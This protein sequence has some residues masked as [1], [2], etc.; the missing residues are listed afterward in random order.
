MFLKNI[1]LYGFKSFLQDTR[2][3]LNP[4]ISVI[5]GPNG[6]G[7]SNVIDA[8][9]WAL[10]E[11]RV[12]ELRAERWEDLLHTDSNNHRAKMAE[13]SLLFDNH[14]KEM[15]DWPESL[16]ITRRYYLSGD[17]EYLLNGRV[18]RLKDIVDL[19]LDSGIG[20]FN[21]AII[22]QG[23]VEA[24]LLM[25]PKERLEQLEEAAGV[26]RYKVKRRETLQHLTDVQ[27]NLD[28]IGDLIADVR[29]Q[30]EEIAED[31]HVEKTYLDI[32]HRYHD[33][34]TRYQ[35]TQYLQAMQD[36]AMWQET[37]ARMN[38]RRADLEVELQ[39]LRSERDQKV[40]LQGQ[41]KERL[42]SAKNTVETKRQSMAVID[43]Y[44]ARLEAEQEGLEREIEGLEEQSSKITC[45]LQDVSEKLANLTDTED[46]ADLDTVQ[47]AS[48]SEPELK[49]M[50]TALDVK[51]RILD[52]Q[53]QDRQ[54]QEAIIK[55][56][57]EETRQLERRRD[58]LE[59]ALN[60]AGHDDLLATVTNW[61][62]EES[63]LRTLYTSTEA[64]Y[65]D[66][67]QTHRAVKQELALV[68]KDIN[69]AQQD[70]WRIEAQIKALRSVESEEE[71]MP[72]S[73]RAVLEMGK[74]GQIAGILG[75]VGSLITIPPRLHRAIDVALR[76]QRYFVI[77]D[78]EIHARH[79]VDW[80]KRQRAG[81]VTLLPLDQIRPALV[82]DRDR[83]LANQPG[84]IGWALDQITFDPELFPA[85]S[86]VLGR[87]LVIESLEAGNALGRLHQFRYR[88][89]SVD[90]Q[91]ILSGGAI[92]GGSES[93]VREKSGKFGALSDRITQL[94]EVLRQ[95]QSR[96]EQLKGE[97]TGLEAKEGQLRQSLGH[98]QERLSQL[99]RILQDGEI[100]TQAV[101]D[102]M[103]ALE[104]AGTR[105]K[106]ATQTLDTTLAT[107]QETEQELQQLKEAYQS[108][109]EQYLHSRQVHSHRLEL[110]AYY[111]E[112]SR[113]LTV[114]KETIQQR[115][116]DLRHSM[117]KVLSQLAVRRQERARMNQQI[118]QKG[119]EV[120]DVQQ[121]LHQIEDALKT[122]EAKTQS[123]MAEDRKTAG[124]INYLEQQLVRTGAKWE[125]YEPAQTEPLENDQLPEAKKMLDEWQNTME[126]LGEVHPGVYALFTQLEKRLEYLEA[127]R[128][129]V[130]LSADELRG[131]LRQIDQEVDLRITKTAQQVETAFNQACSAL[132]G[133]EGGFRWIEGEE[134]GVELRITP[135]GK[136]PGTLSLLSGG[137]KALGGI[138]W[139]FA[140]LSVK[141]S[142]FV[143][144]DEA[145]AALDEANAH[146]VAEYIREHRGKTQY[147]IVTHHK[148]TMAIAD[149]LWGVAGDGKGRSRLVS[150]QI[151]QMPEVREG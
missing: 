132:L 14:D 147:V 36:Q 23:R 98:Y 29:N 69:E 7:K 31:A 93:R 96:Q 47:K 124:R 67:K 19:F 114:Q 10:G 27:R 53:I 89:V 5:V 72:F 113:Q 38:R 133:G 135:P 35:L 24:A 123:I 68:N 95:R 92:S 105:L 84:A 11:Q 52:E 44:I 151:E 48:G 34:Q 1:V 115:L 139:L 109:H 9:R 80:L 66:V 141:S 142:P 39:T 126:S 40:L 140:L 2:V 149:A 131:T 75:T 71:T 106:Q 119:K 127:E 78:T 37:L 6:G 150:V 104:S 82:P 61:E 134:R 148:S 90:G 41:M 120:H 130:E 83:Y 97:L 21:Y 33:L 143:V 102:M 145:E 3:A 13:V 18:V 45:Q 76:A 74:E 22:G 129:D 58:R 59:G 54:R 86:Y 49:S 111:K 64:S 107:I 56:L 125:G 25:K 79:V 15:E 57:A 146:K 94:K 28:R 50:R 77:T 91:V 101:R 122:N 51:A 73:V 12:K 103:S 4:G 128:H 136:K 65:E 62:S 70:L 42:D 60:L 110:L 43:T 117:D 108:R 88:M 100:N 121:Q 81:R 112:E 32:K 138:S 20:R 55:S 17:S 99:K 16:Q 26:S 30:K 116:N 85:M 46:N 8:I 144:L 63:R 118:D 87:V 137:E